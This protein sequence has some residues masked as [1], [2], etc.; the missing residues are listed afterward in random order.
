[1][2][3]PNNFIIFSANKSVVDNQYRESIGDFQYMHK[4]VTQD[5]GASKSNNKI[6]YSCGSSSRYGRMSEMNSGHVSCGGRGRGGRGCVIGQGRGGCSSGGDNFNGVDVSNTFKKLSREDDHKIGK[7]VQEYVKS[8]STEANKNKYGNYYQDRKRGI[9]Q[10][11]SNYY[12]PERITTRI[13][14]SNRN[15]NDKE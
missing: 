6:N 3:V 7:E 8:K 4:N 10:V 13:A 1:M 14:G 9:N 2:Q 5:F 15:V 12:Q 11:E